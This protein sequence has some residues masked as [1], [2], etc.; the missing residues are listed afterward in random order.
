MRAPRLIP[1]LPCSGRLAPSAATALLAVLAALAAAPSEARPLPS[2]FLQDM[3][4]AEL[5]DPL[6]APPDMKPIARL[7][8]AGVRL[9]LG[10]TP[11]AL[12]A[13]RLGLAVEH[14]HDSGQAV[15]W[16]CLRLDVAPGMK[17]PPGGPSLSLWLVSDSQ[18]PGTAAAID[19][20]A[21]DTV[22]QEGRR[23]PSPRREPGLVLDP[24][25]A[26]PG[27]S[28]ERVAQTFDRAPPRTGRAA[29]QLVGP[30]PEDEPLTLTLATRAGRVEALWLAAATE[31]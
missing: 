24:R 18:G 16:L 2:P 14:Q 26:L 20:L 9:R 17:P 30:Q 10:H 5:P 3:V 31:N 13:G 23:C 15:D 21:L 28:L 19:A 27:A 1:T 11:L 8:L 29:Y 25:L 4:R 22:R 6:P 7:S 12:L